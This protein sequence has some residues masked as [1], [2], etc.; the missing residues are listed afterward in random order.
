VRPNFRGVASSNVGHEERNAEPPNPTRCSW[1]GLR[2][3]GVGLGT[4]SR[5]GQFERP[6][7]GWRRPGPARGSPRAGTGH[8]RRPQRSGP[9]NRKL[10]VVR[11]Y[12]GAAKSSVPRPY[13]QTFPGLQSETVPSD[14]G[15]PA[16]VSGIPPAVTFT[17]VTA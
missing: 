6:P 8:R 17:V 11:M 5:L 2:G 10:A 7:V 12:Q 9:A 4:L 3:Y 16:T 1:P 14:A 15:T 13:C